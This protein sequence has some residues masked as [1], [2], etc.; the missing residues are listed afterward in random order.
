MHI[1]RNTT[2]EPDDISGATSL[3]VAV[4][5]GDAATKADS[6][7]SS[8]YLMICSNLA[9]AVSTTKEQTTSVVR[10]KRDG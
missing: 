4:N 5:V 8:V 7:E 10:K 9:C 1:S 3:P 6:A 2:A